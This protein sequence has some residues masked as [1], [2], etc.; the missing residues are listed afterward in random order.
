MVKLV[1]FVIKNFF[2]LLINVSF[3]DGGGG[4]GWDRGGIKRAKQQQ[5]LP[6]L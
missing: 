2:K 4:G 5:K 1:S 6:R 3:G